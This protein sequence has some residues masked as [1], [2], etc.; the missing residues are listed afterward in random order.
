MYMKL[1]DIMYSFAHILRT[2]K[3]TVKKLKV[4]NL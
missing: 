2:E 4:T 1:P 3:Q